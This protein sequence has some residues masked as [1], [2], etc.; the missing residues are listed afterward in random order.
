MPI[1]LSSSLKGRDSTGD[2]IK[3]DEPT[4]VTL[5]N[6]ISLN[7]KCIHRHIAGFLSNDLRKTVSLC[8]KKSATSFSVLCQISTKLLHVSMQSRLYQPLQ[9]YLFRG[10][11]YRAPLACALLPCGIVV[12]HLNNDVSWSV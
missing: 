12:R 9:L 3:Q 10:L 5:W 6:G 7:R 8:S 1:L 2:F 4:A 11:P